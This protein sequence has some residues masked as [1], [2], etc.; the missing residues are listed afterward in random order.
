[1]LDLD[2]IFSSTF[3]DILSTLTPSPASSRTSLSSKIPARDM[4]DRSIGAVLTKFLMLDL[5]ETFSGT[6]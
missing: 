3:K 4:K 2:E 5:D 6:S 1:M